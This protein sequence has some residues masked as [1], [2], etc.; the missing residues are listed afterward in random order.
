VTPAISRS[1]PPYSLTAAGRPLP[2]RFARSPDASPTRRSQSGG[3]AVSPGLRPSEACA[4]RAG[5]PSDRRFLRGDDSYRGAVA[6]ANAHP[7]RADHGPWAE[8]HEANSD[9]AHT[10]LA[11]LRHRDPT[12]AAPR[13]SA[14]SS[15]LELAPKLCYVAPMAKVPPRSP[16]ALRP[17]QVVVASIQPALRRLPGRRVENSINIAVNFYV[18]SST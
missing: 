3:A 2:T 7:D 4:A 1:P 17:V 8:L 13:V 9:L 12:M 16:E 5:Q 10:L 6:G 18:L 15:G 11:Q 14:A